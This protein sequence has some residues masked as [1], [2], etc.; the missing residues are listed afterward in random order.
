VLV[1]LAVGNEDEL[2]VVQV[3]RVVVHRGQTTVATTVPPGQD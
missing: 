2:A 3:C 1:G